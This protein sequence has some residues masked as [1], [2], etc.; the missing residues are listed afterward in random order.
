MPH[1]IDTAALRAFVVVSEA[2]GMTRAAPLLNLTQGAVSQ[3]IK[4]LETLFDQPLFERDR[5]SLR[6]TPAGERLLPRARA[7]LETNDAI[8]TMMTAPEVEGTV[9]MGVPDD[10]VAPYMPC[11]L[12]SFAREWPGLRVDIVTATSPILRRMLD[13]GEVDLTLTTERHP[14]PEAEIMATE[15]LVWVGAPGGLAHTRRPLPIAL[16]DETCSFRAST[17]AALADAGVDW[18]ATISSMTN[19]ESLTAMVA[20]DL[21]VKVVIRAGVPP[22]LRALGPESG[23]P[24]LPAFHVALYTPATPRSRGAAM[25][26]DHIRQ[27]FVRDQGAKEPAEAAHAP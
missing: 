9:R 26:A 22:G 13:A 27:T 19:M 1:N 18:A 4:R 14:A 3:Q 5:K 11:I 24:T 10:I 21:A 12:K 8:W 16:G 2:G 25:L 7:L 6:L 17:L 20:A 23:L 15:P